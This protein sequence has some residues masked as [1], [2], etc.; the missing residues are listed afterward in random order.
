VSA[1]DA[2]SDKG[3]GAAGVGAAFISL[4]EFK[5][6]VGKLPRDEFVAKF[7]HPVLLLEK[8]EGEFADPGFQT[9]FSAKA[10]ADAD[11]DIAGIP[12]GQR[13][14]VGAGFVIETKPQPVDPDFA[15]KLADNESG[16]HVCTLQKR[17]PNKFAS[18]ITVGRAANNDVRI[19]LPSVSK[20]HCY[21]TH[22]PRDKVWFIT[23]ANSSNGTW[24]DGERLK[25]DRGRAKLS[26]GTAIR[27]GPDVV[28][29]FFEAKS[30]F[31][32]VFGS[33]H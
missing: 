2:S 13:D 7:P 14:T 29:R 31:E 15:K 33:A 23:D 9:V 30:L 4:R 21:F 11:V 24:V 32:Y 19:N 6:R 5:G 26:N 12:G 10:E 25:A 22:I 17:D 1:K 28:V 8:K 27:I 16:L 20:F 18:M 3:K